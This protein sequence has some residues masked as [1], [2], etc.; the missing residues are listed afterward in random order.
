MVRQGRKM[1]FDILT[2]SMDVA[3]EEYIEFRTILLNEV[4]KRSEEYKKTV[5]L[6][7]LKFKMEDYNKTE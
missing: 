1:D 4:K 6:L 5:E 7:A 3:T 2:E